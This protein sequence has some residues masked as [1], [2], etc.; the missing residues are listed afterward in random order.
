MSN[1]TEL[2]RELKILRISSA[3]SHDIVM[4]LSGR[5]LDCKSQDTAELPKTKLNDDLTLYN[6]A[7]L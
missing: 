7:W 4:F 2:N 6:I 1:K 3:I 5:L